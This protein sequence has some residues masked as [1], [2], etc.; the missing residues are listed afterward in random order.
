MPSISIISLFHG[1]AE[2]A[3]VCL[4]SL[5]ASAPPGELEWLLGE[6]GSLDS[7]PEVLEKFAAEARAKGWGA[8]V[9]RFG[10]N[11]GAV[12]GRNR[13]MERA[14]GELVVFLDSDVALRSGDWLGGLARRLAEDERRGI[15]APKLVYPRPPHEI[16]CAG[17]EVT[18]GG[19]VIFRGRGESRDE[20]RWSEP[21]EVRAVI[22]ACWMMRRAM[23]EE[24]GPLDE[25]YS[26]IQYEDTDYC[27]RARAAG[28]GVFYAPEVEMYH[29]ENVTSSR[30]STLNYNYLTVKNGL[31][32]REKWREMLLREGGPPDEEWSW[33]E[34]APV[35][36][37]EVR[38]LPV[39]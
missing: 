34:V 37:A 39:V 19:R 6:N 31:Y 22:S 23:W 17:C 2:F 11:L 18:R 33:R 38:E 3:E 35:R 15:V 25:A 13:L 12:R 14:R 7:T 16:Q 30:S 24:L 8:E 1:H 9:V 10:E 28:W 29:F 36:L 32:F 5:L 27:Y 26:P 21:G 20:E 4:R